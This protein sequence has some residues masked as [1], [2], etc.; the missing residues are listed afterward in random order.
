MI[1][2]VDFDKWILTVLPSFLRRR[3]LFALCRALCAPVKTLYGRFLDARDA[4]IY[5]LTHSGQV[6]YLRAA[7]NDAFHS[8]GFDIVDY[9][10]Q[11]GE[12]VY[13]KADNMAGQLKAKEESPD[14]PG[15]GDP[16]MPI[17]YDETRLNLPQ[18]YFVVMVPG[19]IYTTRL[20]KVKTIVDKYRLLSKTPI[21][22]PI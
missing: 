13:A 11:R 18:N 6:C 8:K 1:F 17:L 3:V 7:L 16:V 20:D 21:Y 22:T 12:W 4:H 14:V 15:D 5:R 10:D 9:D 19:S 2:R